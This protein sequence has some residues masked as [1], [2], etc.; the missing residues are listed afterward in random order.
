M[1]RRRRRPPQE[2]GVRAATPRAARSH[3]RRA[4]LRS[5]S[6]VAQR[7][8]GGRR[9]PH[10]AA[11]AAAARRR[12]GPRLGRSPE[13]R[14]R[15]SPRKRRPAP[16][17][18]APLC[19]VHA[20]RDH[21]ASRGLRDPDR[22]PARR[23]PRTQRHRR[24]AD[25]RAPDGARRDGHRLPLEDEGP[26]RHLP[27]SGHPR[28]GH[29]A[30]GI[31]DP[32]VREGGSSRSGRG[33]QSPDGGKCAGES[34]AFGADPPDARREGSRSRRRRGL[35]RRCAGRGR[36]EPGSRRCGTVDGGAAAPEHCKGGAP[37]QG[38]VH[39][40]A[41]RAH[42]RRGGRA[43]RAHCRAG[44]LGWRRGATTRTRSSAIVPAGRGRAP[45]RSGAC[46]A[47]P[48]SLRTAAW[49]ASRLG[50]RGA[51]DPT[52]RRRLEAAVHP[53]VR[54]GVATV[55]RG[56]GGPGRRRRSPWWRRR[57]WSR[58]GRSATTTGS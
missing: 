47:A 2:V 3:G 48:S 22:G 8:P 1:C 46:S 43:A 42:G 32:R 40:A 29:R 27:R 30:S 12:E 39:D 13:G 58:P 52:A 55:A 50:G 38:V 35:R 31:R 9:D 15:L 7:G 51:P 5:L 54:A 56:A 14:R 24:Q 6:R 21:G 17:G 4:T 28:R 41:R 16:P 23:R 20:G 11:A 26:A 36:A 25:G 18:T 19:A 53:L 34:P 45:G 57:C 10:P 37:P 44:W 49:T 33:H